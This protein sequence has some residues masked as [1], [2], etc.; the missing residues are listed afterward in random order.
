[1]HLTMI[2]TRGLPGQP[3]TSLAVADDV[4]HVNGTAYD[5][6]AV[7]EG[8]DGEWPDSPLLGRIQRT[9]DVIHVTVRVQLDDTAA[10]DQPT[11]PEH[12]IVSDARGSIVIPAARRP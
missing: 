1:M 10:N 2:P 7:P 11:D 12:W 6:S 9:D 4:I 5:L 8:G 3:E